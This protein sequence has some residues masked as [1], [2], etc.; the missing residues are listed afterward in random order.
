ML[1]IL[2][3]ACTASYAQRRAAAQ[4]EETKTFEEAM[5]R[6]VEPEVKVYVRPKVADLSIT[7][8][9]RQYYGPYTYKVKNTLTEWEF[10][11]HGIRPTPAS[12]EAAFNFNA[13]G[14]TTRNVPKS[15]LNETVTDVAR[16]ERCP[17]LGLRLKVNLLRVFL[18]LNTRLDNLVTDVKRRV[19]DADLT[20]VRHN[21]AHLSRLLLVLLELLQDSDVGDEA[22]KAPTNRNL[23]R[24][25]TALS[26]LGDADQH[27]SQ[28]HFWKVN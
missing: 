17:V 18:L 8:P 11:N 2:M 13:N 7:S 10:E 15:E 3:L 1:S 22:P 25:N 16:K 6:M 20:V 21:V 9:Q 24:R 26:L 23:P 5:T 14:N 12:N 27:R 28:N 19:I 4:Q